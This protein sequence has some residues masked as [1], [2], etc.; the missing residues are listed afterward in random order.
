[1]QRI[2]FLFI[3]ILN[4]FAVTL[5]AQKTLPD[6]TVKN[7]NGQIIVSWVNNY[8][9]PVTTIN[10][11]RSYDSLKN[12]TT[13]GSVLNPQNIENG[14][15]DS[16]P[17]YNKM[18]YRV[19]ISFDGGSYIF[20]KV[21][22]PVKDVV[23]VVADSAANSYNNGT[24]AQ[25]PAPDTSFP[26]LIRGR[27]KSAVQT[28]NDPKNKD[29]RNIQPKTTLPAINNPDLITYPSRRIFTA[30]D[31]NVVIYLP[32]AETKKYM[33]KFFEENETPL[34]EL[35]KLHEDYL[36]IEKVNFVHAGWFHFE[37]Y[38]NG[39]LIEKNKFFI[40]KDGKVSN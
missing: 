26:F 23:E 1:M 14:Y 8:K 2:S 31:N 37:I 32:G 20:S 35:T 30:K 11:Q 10:I 33:V 7:L 24:A 4:L 17:P 40:A 21:A 22:R 6:I 15:A 19:F 18:Y 27:D 25:Q 5:T 16:K 34:F 29:P 28:I 39:K 9:V 36:I 12:Y 38:E 3:L 13:I